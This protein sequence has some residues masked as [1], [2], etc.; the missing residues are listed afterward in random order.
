VRL[1]TVVR[2]L[3]DLQGILHPSA[4]RFGRRGSLLFWNDFPCIVA[5]R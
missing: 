1:P 3:T 5:A 4:A 2:F